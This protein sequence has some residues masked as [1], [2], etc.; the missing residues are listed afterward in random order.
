MSQSFNWKTRKVEKTPKYVLN[1][2]E[3]FSEKTADPNTLIRQLYQQGST[4]LLAIFLKP[5]QIVSNNLILHPFCLW[6]SWPGRG[7]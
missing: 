1:L 4:F 3:M 2:T 5:C 7:T 6:H